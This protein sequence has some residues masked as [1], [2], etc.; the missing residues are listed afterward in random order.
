MLEE[1]PLDHLDMVAVDCGI[2][3]RGEKGPRLEQIK[4]IKAREVYEGQISAAHARMHG[5]GN[6]TS[7][8]QDLTP[9]R[10]SPARLHPS[11]RIMAS[12]LQGLPALGDLEGGRLRS[13][14][15]PQHLASPTLPPV[16]G[17]HLE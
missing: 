9:W 13:R 10:P 12:P 2:V 1:V 6:G 3:F 4:A 14:R 8:W 15:A 17:H 16:R 11:T 7:C 5:S